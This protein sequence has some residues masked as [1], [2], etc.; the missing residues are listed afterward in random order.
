MSL[1]NLDFI[2]YNTR[3]AAVV[4]SKL[5]PNAFAVTQLSNDTKWW[6]YV[7]YE[8]GVYKIHFKDG[9]Y[10]VPSNQTQTFDI[11]RSRLTT[12]TATHKASAYIT[13]DDLVNNFIDPN[14]IKPKTVITNTK[15]LKTVL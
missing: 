13:E 10:T 9:S 12:S 14:S 1:C 15:T 8:S 7:S 6:Y 11:L 5:N 3:A 4:A 2:P